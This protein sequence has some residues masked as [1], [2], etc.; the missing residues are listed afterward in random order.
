MAWNSI[1]ENEI[2]DVKADKKSADRVEKYMISKKAIYFE[3]KYL[4]ISQ[5]QSV[6]IHD[7][8]YNPH[9]CCGRGIPVKKLKIEYGAD[10]P[11]ILMLENEKNANKLYDLITE[12]Q[13]DM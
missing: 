4:P 6:S 12:A 7:S 1:T 9:C 8:T 3:G 10:K 5:I 11:L 2:E 13:K